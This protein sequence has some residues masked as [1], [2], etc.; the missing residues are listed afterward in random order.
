MNHLKLFWDWDAFKGTV[1]AL[2]AVVLPWLK[3]LTPP[4]QFL[5]VVG[6]LVLLFYSIKHKRME[7]KKLKGK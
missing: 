5:G 2:M 3:V 7:I 4:L 6:G 1:G